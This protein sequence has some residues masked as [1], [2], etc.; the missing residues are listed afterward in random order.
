MLKG[1]TVSR[2]SFFMY[3][4]VLVLTFG[5]PAFS[6]L[7]HSAV[8]LLFYIE[9]LN[10]P[11]TY[12]K[13]NWKIPLWYR[14]YTPLS[15]KPQLKLALGI[16]E[17]SYITS[18]FCPTWLLLSLSSYVVG[19]LTLTCPFHPCSNPSHLVQHFPSRTVDQSS[20]SALMS[21]ST[22]FY[23]NFRLWACISR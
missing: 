21:K 14:K 8:G 9:N 5:S 23:W 16:S 6:L 3:P 2:P 1:K 20:N 7:L 12:S 18:V 4:L 11:Q 17:H 15:S 13:N 10:L 19:I 22:G